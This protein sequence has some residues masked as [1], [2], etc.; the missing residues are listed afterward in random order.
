MTIY[1]TFNKWIDKRMTLANWGCGIDLT[2]HTISIQR[3]FIN[4]KYK[5]IEDEQ[6]YRRLMTIYALN[7][8][9]AVT[10]LAQK[11]KSKKSSSPTTTACYEDVSDDDEIINHG[12]DQ[13]SMNL[14]SFDDIE[15][16][17]EIYTPTE[18]LTLYDDN[19]HNEPYEMVSDDG[20]D[21]FSLPEIMKVHLPHKPCH[22]NEPG[23]YQ[24]N[25][26]SIIMMM[27]GF[28]LEMKPQMK[29]KLSPTMI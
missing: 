23:T 9:L 2:L 25:N 17:V 1:L 22:S 16:H 21:N 12:N 3:Q 6:K 27:K 13:Q 7:D 8:C 15:D 29:L 26:Y 24:A 11:I 14:S 28:I 5:I 19:V 4:M 18:I 20:L 10:Q